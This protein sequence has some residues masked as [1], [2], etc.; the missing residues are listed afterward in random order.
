M[1]RIA[2][3]D[4]ST[5][6]TRYNAYKNLHLVDASLKLSAW[7]LANEENELSFD[8]LKIY[9]L[10]TSNNNGCNTLCISFIQR[11]SGFCVR[12]ILFWIYPKYVKHNKLYVQDLQMFSCGQLREAIIICKGQIHVWNITTSDYFIRWSDFWPIYTHV[13]ARAKLPWKKIFEKP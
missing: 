6:N 12:L 13:I 5:A 10:P 1:Q 3:S 11:A 9:F 7:V 2:F 4:Q 8:N